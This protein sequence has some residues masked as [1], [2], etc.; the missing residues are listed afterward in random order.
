MDISSLR[1]RQDLSPLTVSELNDRIQHILENTPTLSRL[2]VRGEISNFTRHTTG[3]LYFTLKDAN[4]Q[5]RCVMF[6]SAAARLRFAPSDGMKVLLHGSVTVF[7]KSGQYQINADGMQPDGIGALYMA[8]EQLKEKLAAEGLF[9]QSHKLPLPAYPKRI[10]I[11]TSPTGAAVRDIIDVCGRR[12]PRAQLY[13]YPSLVQGE[14]A[15]DGL[16]AALEYFEKSRLC[17]TVIIGRGGGSIEDLWAFND[18]RLARV[19]YAMT[20]PVVSAVGHETDFTICDFVAD[21]RAPTPSAAAE[22]CTPD[23]HELQLYLD[24]IPNRAKRALYARLDRMATRLAA[25]RVDAVGQRVARQWQRTQEHVQHLGKEALSA[26]NGRMQSLSASLAEACA[27]ADALSPLAV[28]R[29]GYAVIE[30]EGHLVKNIHD[31]TRGQT[32]QIR[33]QDG[34]ACARITDT[35]TEK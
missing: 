7:A 13:L 30:E 20:L 12:Y 29:R 25:M 35:G 2:H 23:R 19:L 31:L 32:V 27:R 24:A 5:I 4:G 8:Y 21:L 17:D 26:W 14:G 11:I 3:H 22:L 16:I 34:T 10:G 15:A 1:Q 18:E 33:M 28:L 9:D 6:R